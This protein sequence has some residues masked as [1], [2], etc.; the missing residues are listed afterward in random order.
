VTARLRR[1]DTTWLVTCTEPKD[2]P[3]GP[4]AVLVAV[5]TTLMS[6]TSRA[7]VE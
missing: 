1:N 5:S 6:V 7:N 3:T 2:S 4:H